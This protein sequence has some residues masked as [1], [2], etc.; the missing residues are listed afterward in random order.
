MKRASSIFTH[1]DRQRVE[2]AVVDAEAKTSCE[3][4]PVVATASGRYDR[5]EDIVGLWFAIIAAVLFWWFYP[6]NLA[7][8]GNWGSSSTSYRVFFLVV[9]M[10]AAFFAGAILGSRIAWLRRL[11]TPKKQMEEDVAQRARQIFY[12]NRVH[13]TEGATGL[14]VYI[15]LFEHEAIILGDQAILDK[16]GQ[17]FLDDLCKHLTSVLHEGKPTNALCDVIQMAGEQLATPLPR[18]AD[19]VNELHDT[20]VLLD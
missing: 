4:V 10:V 19:D 9:A 16:L 13:H 17:G 5:P 3:I 1:E 8:T 7:E 20:L 2:Q 11:F 14:L 15:S 18:A 6:H 12:D